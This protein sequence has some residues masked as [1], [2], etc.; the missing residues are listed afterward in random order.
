MFGVDVSSELT[1]YERIDVHVRGYCISVTRRRAGMMRDPF[2][3][4]ERILFEKKIFRTVWC[5]GA[6]DVLFLGCASV[7]N[8]ISGCIRERYRIAGS[9]R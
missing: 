5:A 9:N 4:M 3:C 6:V 7:V 8:L 1:V 2:L